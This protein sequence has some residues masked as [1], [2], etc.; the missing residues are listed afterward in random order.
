MQHEVRVTRTFVFQGDDIT[1]SVDVNGDLTY[2]TE[3]GSREG[4]D[5]QICVVVATAGLPEMLEALAA[6]VREEQAKP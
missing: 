6:F 5:D 4:D 1:Y 2:I 3:P